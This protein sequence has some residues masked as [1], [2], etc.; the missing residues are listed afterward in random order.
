MRHKY[1]TFRQRHCTFLKIFNIIV[2]RNKKYDLKNL[3]IEHIK[4]IFLGGQLWNI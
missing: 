1:T 2:T 4:K 3:E